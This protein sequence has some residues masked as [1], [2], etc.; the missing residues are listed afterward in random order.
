LRQA[1]YEQ[2]CWWLAQGV[3]VVPLKPCS[4]YL[5]P[6]Y[7]A[8]QAHIGTNE[9]AYQWFLNTNANL[10]IVL[11]GAAGIAV[12]D[13]D[14][15]LDYQTWRQSIGAEVDTLIEQT[16]RG[17]HVFFLDVHFT[18]PI[19]SGGCEFKTAGVCMVSPST[20]PSGLV[21]RVV[22]GTSITPLSQEGAQHL[23]P[24][25]SKQSSEPSQC[26]A[27]LSIQPM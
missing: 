8:R 5:Q 4:K 24:F 14:D 2:A 22:S 23:F 12:A 17:Y 7:G 16:G 19:R 1:R 6:G 10:G 3:A 20:H 25:L 11:G 9:S 27:W 13:W 21:Y 18:W 26:W 15:H